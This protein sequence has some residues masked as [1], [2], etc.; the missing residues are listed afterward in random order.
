MFGEKNDGFIGLLVGFGLGFIAAIILYKPQVQAAQQTAQQ[1]T[2]DQIQI[3]SLSGW[4]PLSAIPSVDRLGEFKPMPV[5]EITGNEERTES[6]QSTPVTNS[7]ML[8]TTSYKNSEKWKVKRDPATGRI[9]GYE[10]DRDA[11][12]G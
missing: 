2:E 8:S 4:R 11:K 10:V 12:I 3:S 9:V 5:L 6:I 1:T 7:N